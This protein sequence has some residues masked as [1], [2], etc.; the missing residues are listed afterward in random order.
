[1]QWTCTKTDFVFD[2]P[3][4]K[5]WLPARQVVQAGRYPRTKGAEDF[6]RSIDL[7][8]YPKIIMR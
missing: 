6:I 3:T 5:S 8:F 4:T 2:L 1:L 7:G